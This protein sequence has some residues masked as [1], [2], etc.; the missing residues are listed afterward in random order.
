MQ[1]YYAVSNEF[2]NEKQVKR[3]LSHQ[4]FLGKFPVNNFVLSDAEDNT[5]EPLKRG[6]IADLPLLKTL[7]K[8]LYDPFLWMATASTLQPLRGGSWLCE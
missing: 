4:E 7:L 3:Y 2:W 5:F 1:K 6:G 8:K